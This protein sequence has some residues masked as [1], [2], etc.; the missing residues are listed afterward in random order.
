MKKNNNMSRRKFLKYFFGSVFIAGTGTLAY[1]HYVERYWVNTHRITLPFSPLPKS[2]SKLKI[3]HFSDVHLGHYFGINELTRLVEQMNQIRPDIICFTG[4]L[5]ENEL[6]LLDK[7]VS[8]LSNLTAPLGKYAVLGNHDYWFDRSSVANTLT[9]SGF[10]VLVN[11]HAVIQHAHERIY[12]SGVDD[13]LYGSPNIEQA[14]EGI[15]DHEFTILLAHEPDY[16]DAASQYPINLQL[17]GHSHGGQIKF[18]FIGHLV[19]PP[20]GRKYVDRLNQIGNLKVYTNR[21]VGTTGIPFR[22]N[23]RPEI[24]VIELVTKN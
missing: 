7:S 18:P 6:E 23:C 1:A 16:A 20:L 13:I 12:V 2:F 14:I 11:N 21:G 5:V 10:T 9:D 8:I 4:D 3:L 15:P 19:T 24:T 17:S 22:F